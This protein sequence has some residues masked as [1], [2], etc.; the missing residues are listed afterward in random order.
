MGGTLFAGRAVV[1]EALAAR[2]VRSVVEALDGRIDH[3]CFVSSASVYA[4]HQPIGAD[5]S[6]P[7]EELPTDVD[8]D[9]ETQITAHY[10]A[11][12]AC[13]ER[14][15]DELLPGRAHHA[16]AGI[17]VGPHDD[18]GRFAYWLQ[19]IAAGG[20]VLAPDPPD[21]PIQ[22][23]DVRDLAAWL[24][25][26]AEHGVTGPVNAVGDPGQL[27]MASLLG[28]IDA[29]AGNGAR[30]VWVDQSFLADEG[31]EPWSDLPLWLP[32]A[33]LPT[34]VGFFQRSN[35]RAR[36]AG[37]TFR[38]LAVTIAD[39]LDWLSSGEPPPRN[40][41]LDIGRVGLSDERHRSLLE[42]WER[43]TVR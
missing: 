33:T 40:K 12:K 3:Y 36:A 29:V 1:A 39:T 20:D 13:C 23:I 7:V 19:R 32:P 34:H 28:E 15:L 14:T 4:S 37:L 17:I 43:R 10:G 30:L 24:L 18:S 11:L 6:A 5:E 25:T 27:T 22:M 42:R 21:N 8:V 9:D 16:R 35:A 41:P 38:S 31:I 26:A 2:H